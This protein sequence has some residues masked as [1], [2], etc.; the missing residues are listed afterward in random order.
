VVARH[1][2][3]LRDRVHDRE[4]RGRPFRHRHRD[5]AIELDDGRA[6]H[7]R[8][9]RVQRRHARPVGVARRGRTRVA[10]RDRCLQRVEARGPSERFGAGERRETAADEQTVPSR[11]VLV[12]QQHGLAVE[13]EARVRARCLDLHERDQAVHLRL[14]R[15]QLREDAAE[16]KRVGAELGPLPRVARGRRVPLVEDEVDDLEHRRE[17][18]LERRAPGRLER[19]LGLGERPL[20]AHDPLRDR[21]LRDEERA[22]DLVGREAAEQ[23]QRQRDARLGREHGVARDEDEAQE[24]VAHVVV[25]GLFDR[26]APAL[27]LGL[28]VVP[29]RLLRALGELAAAQAVDGAVLRRRHEPRAGVVGH[30]RLGPLL[31]RRHERVLREL[32][33]EADVAHHAREAGDDPRRLDP[34]D[35]VDRAA[36]AHGAR[37]A[38]AAQTAAVASSSGK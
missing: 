1:R 23:A 17:A 5:G 25:D 14:A 9:H 26:L 8:E 32:L 33:G 18:L 6:G 19:D 34:P 3:V 12:H 37:F 35:G 36:N 20:G 31:E 16:A 29:H 24:V 7:A 30:A 22:R 38:I 4:A 11:A 13:P 10:R 15:H 28:G 21:R 2:G 27:F